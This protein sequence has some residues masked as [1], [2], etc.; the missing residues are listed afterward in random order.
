[1]K[2]SSKRYTKALEVADLENGYSVAEAIELLKKMPKAKFDETVVLSVHLGVDPKQS[3]QMVRG[4]VSLP[5]GSGR[6]VKVLAFTDDPVSA[7]AAG[8]D[9]AGLHDVLQKINDGWL[10]FDVAVATTSAMKEVRSA[11]RILGPRGLMP[12][13][14][15]GTVS[16]DLSSAIQAVKSGRVEFKMDKTANLAIVIGKRSFDG[17]KLVENCERAIDVLSKM[18]PVEFRGKFVESMTIAGS[19]TPG[20]R[21]LQKIFGKF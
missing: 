1:M 20:V 2:K 8:A 18:R 7:L 16:D 3:D 6:R 9:E 14:K 10:D 19:M 5:H 12:N 15:T 13:P 21:L 11:A 4:T 17:P